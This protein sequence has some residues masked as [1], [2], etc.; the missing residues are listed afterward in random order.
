MLENEMLEVLKK[1]RDEANQTNERLGQTNERLRSLEEST[2]RRFSEPTERTDRNQSEILEVHRRQAD[3]DFR[4]TTEGIELGNLTRE[5][6]G[7]LAAKLDDHDSV[8][9]HER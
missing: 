2:N 7:L 5:I 3:T 4:L 6:R 1:I 8:L 9:D